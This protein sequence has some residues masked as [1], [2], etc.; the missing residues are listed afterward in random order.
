MNKQR[1]TKIVATLGPSSSSDTTI[2]ALISAGVDVFRLNFSHGHVDDHR[3][4]AHSVRTLAAAAGRDVALLGD[5]QGPKIRIRSFRDGAVELEEGAAFTLDCELPDGDGDQTRVGVDL[6]SLPESV[7][8]GDVLILDDGR[9]SLD[10]VGVRGRCVDCRV[11]MAG[12]LSNR[13]GLNR[14]GGGLSAPSLTERD[15]QDIVHAAELDLDYL[16]VSF[17][18]CAADIHQARRL[19]EASGSHA[20]IIAKIE[21]AEVVQDESILDELILAA[22]GIMVAR[23]DLG[24]EVGDAQ[25]IGIQKQLISKAR[26][27]DRTVITATQM[28]E[29]MV[30]S[31]IPTRAEVF[32]V[33]NA[34]LDG[35]DAVMLSAETASGRFPV[36]TVK[37]MASTCLGAESYPGVRR[38]HHRMDR[39]FTRVDETI[40]MAAVYAANHLEGVAGMVCLTESGST[41]LRMSRM[42]SGLPIFALSRHPSIVRRMCLYRGVRPVLFDYTV[43][44]AGEVG[45]E[46]VAALQRLGLVHSGERLILTRGDL[47]G[48]GGS[49]TT[50][51]IIEL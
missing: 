8:A 43:F 35:T 47:L 32:D 20:R 22:D 27:M 1:R 34:V 6:P 30:H 42:S 41:A 16:A 18:L 26:R 39:E 51:K 15:L 9:M 49:T 14:L 38:S 36:E 37:A 48:V 46:A 33:A 10:V 24:V 44:P 2:G 23:G 45:Q 19:V 3:A 29:S 28:M 31:P 11:R 7:F 50:L 17:P 13:K 4:R 5:L 40:A 21:R 12:R 25:L